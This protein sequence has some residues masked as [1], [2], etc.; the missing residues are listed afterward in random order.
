VR[1]PLWL[2]D[3][4][5]LL[6]ELYLRRG[7]QNLSATDSDV[8]ELSDVLNRI[9]LHPLHTRTP[10]FRNPSGIS[11]KIAN[12]R[13]IDPEAEGGGLSAASDI[14]RA[15]WRAFAHRVLDLTA[16][17]TT[18]REAVHAKD[19]VWPEANEGFLE[20]RIAETRHKRYERSKALVEAKL[21]WARRKFGK[22]SCEAC[23]FNFTLVYGPLGEGYIECHHKEPLHLNS[24]RNND[25]ND[26]ALLCA[27]CHR[28]IHR[29]VKLGLPLM[30]ISQLK[31]LILAKTYV[32]QRKPAGS[33][34]N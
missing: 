2:Y 3:E 32:A 23:E 5:L 10:S 28:M 18:I 7:R 17:T 22:L 27:N 1:N 12:L 21:T 29:S 9:S 14:D 15:V 16:L 34:E 26:L 13:S 4:A 25:I 8:M 31:S 24:S 6:L 33:D 11:M 19:E 20:G 30:T